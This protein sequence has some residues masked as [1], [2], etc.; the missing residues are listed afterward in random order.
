MPQANRTFRVFVSS[1]FSD[2]KAERDALQKSV[3]PRLKELCM[4][5]GCQFQAIDLR[6]GISEEAALDQQTMK[7]CFQEIRRCQEITPRPNFI[8]LQGDR[9]GWQPLPSEIPADEFEQ[10]EKTVLDKTE[11]KLLNKWYLRDENAI[12]WH[13]RPV[14]AKYLLKPR[15]GKFE[16]YKMWEEEV[17]QP[18]RSVLRNA[19]NQFS[20]STADRLK[21]DSSATHQEIWCGALNVENAGYHVFGFFRHIDNLDD[22]KA[23][24]QCTKTASE[25]IDTFVDEEGQRS[26]DHAAYGDL[27]KLQVHLS[28]RLPK[29]NVHEYCSKWK[30]GSV[31]TDHIGVLTDDFEKCLEF[32]DD[33]PKPSTCLCEDVWQRLGLVIQNEIRQMKEI[34][35][36]EQENQVH[37]KVVEEHARFFIGRAVVLKKIRTHLE[38]DNSYPLVIIGEVGS[39]KS[40]LIA[41]AVE[42]AKEANNNAFILTRF[43][44]ETPASSDIRSLLITFVRKSCGSIDRRNLKP[45]VDSQTL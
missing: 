35:P 16:D 41:R 17:E 11:Q 32:L 20:I 23:D 14:D 8:V 38:G 18:L 31:T 26:F 21:Y 43:V 4:R 24:I 44:G 13:D 5:Y 34:H 29:E 36:L 45:Q 9:Y 28:S 7:V 40:A 39:G 3:F 19:I 30:D 37:G 25:F 1:T 6:W 27:Q 22:V 2:L 15:D 42:Q 10:I 12:R 33:N